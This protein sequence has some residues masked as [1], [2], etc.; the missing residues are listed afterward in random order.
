MNL[1][2]PTAISDPANYT[3]EDIQGLYVRR[4]KK[5]VIGGGEA[6][7]ERE[8]K[9]HHTPASPVED[10]LF[11]VLQAANFQTIHPRKQAVD[12]A[13]GAD[14]T[15]ANPRKKPGGRDILFR[16]L[17]MKALL[18][19]PEA[20]RQTVLQRLKHKRLQPD[21]QGKLDDAAT[22]D[23]ELLESIA[24]LV[25]ETPSKGFAKLDAC[26]QLLESMGIKKNGSERVVIFSERIATL[27]LLEQLLVNKLKL[28]PDQVG[29]FHGSLDDQK[30]QRLVKE[31]GSEK[32]SVRVLLASDAASE[33]INLHHY[34]H[35]MIHFDIPWSLMTL[36][37]RNGR[38]D[39]YGQAHPPQIHY[40]LTVPGD[41]AIRGDLR[42]LDLL[43]EREQSAHQNLGDARWLLGLHDAA[44]EE[45]HVAAG[46]S[47]GDDPEA[48]VPEVPDDEEEDFLQTLFAAY[49]Q[50]TQAAAER[51]KPRE[52]LSLYDDDLAF[53]RHAFEQ[54]VDDGTAKA[55]EWFDEADGLLITPPDDL[56]RRYQL[57]P[58]ELGRD[59]AVLK[60][61]QDRDRVMTA[62]EQSRQDPD[63]WPE[64]Q[65]LW[66]L[67][68][69]MEWLTDRVLSAYRR[70]EAPLLRLQQ[71][72]ER[73]EAIFLFQGV[74]SN[75]RSQPMLVDWFG[76]S[77]RGDK[78]ADDVWTLPGLVRDLKLNQALSNDTKAV[79]ASRLETLRHRAVERA[80]EQMHIRRD[81]RAKRLHDQ[82]MANKKRLKGWRNR[83]LQAI[84][85]ER[86]RVKDAGRK[87][88]AD[89]LRRWEQREADLQAR[90]DAHNKWV[91]ETLSTSK[92][93]Y[94]CL[95]A[96][97]AH[98]EHPLL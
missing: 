33:G 17:L 64:W 95:A 26:V 49:E 9:L 63:E 89:Q 90:V 91:T 92:L 67:H 28:K 94:L 62:L 34:C 36:E 69:A 48:I 16:T 60:L 97:I 85:T 3:K 65:L 1:L 70:H 30:Q 11:H 98:A 88:R 42:V 87:P 27:Q 39:R 66:E 40:L 51:P 24:R 61:T 78:L 58:P 8:L 43:I 4:F 79:D 82:V 12:I 37:Q 76:V 18:S 59:E 14:A 2:D 84:E 21:D 55:P 83:G 7:H 45:D 19:S 53:T 50:D 35:R 57:L 86:E 20:L 74:L 75:Q 41:A 93:P 68:P 56:K 80:T 73:D 46:I 71:G 38:I 13:P 52:Q 47:A 6:F 10:E 44:A 15:A 72:L 96:V 29:V 31:F 22:H 25:P 77:F 32:T 54:M 5:D 23:R 81:E